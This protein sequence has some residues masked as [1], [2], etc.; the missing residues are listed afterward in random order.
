[1]PLKKL[2]PIVHGDV[3][4]AIILSHQLGMGDNCRVFCHISY[5]I[6]APRSYL[7]KQLFKKTK[8]PIRCKFGVPDQQKRQRY[9]FM[10]P[11]HHPPHEVVNLCHDTTVHYSFDMAQQ[12]SYCHCLLNL[13]KH[14]EQVHYLHN[15]LQPGPMYFLIPRKCAIFGVCCEG[16]P[17][18]VSHLFNSHY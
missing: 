6:N 11:S 1:M 5:I 3:D 16:V 18:Q 8:T 4:S 14:G 2:T 13:T 7:L 17:R 9:F 12:V 15:P 10:E